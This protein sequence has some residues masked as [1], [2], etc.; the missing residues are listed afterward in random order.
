MSLYVREELTNLQRVFD[1]SDSVQL[2]S[3]LEFIRTPIGKTGIQPAAP[4]HTH[5]K[6]RQTEEKKS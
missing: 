6:K 2:L 4:G 1:G 3:T 5:T